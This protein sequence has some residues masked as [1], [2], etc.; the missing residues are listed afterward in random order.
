[1]LRWMSS[2][3]HRTVE[4]FDGLAAS[5]TSVFE[6]T[7]QTML[8]VKQQLAAV[9]QVVEAMETINTGSKEA[10]SGIGQT[11]LGVQQLN[12]VAQS[13]QVIGVHLSQD[14]RKSCCW[15]A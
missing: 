1:M 10:S 13:L 9:R 3:T 11:K 6:S 7:Q 12:E 15:E 2:L 5:I 8:N 4:V 14:R